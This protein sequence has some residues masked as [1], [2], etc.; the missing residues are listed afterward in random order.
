MKE[1]A[2]L[3]FTNQL[4]VLSDVHGREAALG[5]TVFNGQYTDTVSWSR[6]DMDQTYIVTNGQGSLP[7]NVYQ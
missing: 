7:G 1:R 6:K 4:I 5:K 3:C 2:V